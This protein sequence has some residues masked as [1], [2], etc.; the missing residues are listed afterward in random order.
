MSFTTNRWVRDEDFFG[1]QELLS[2]LRK[3]G[4]KAAWVLGNRR[5]G[6][7]S[8][9][10]QIEWLCKK[11]HWPE[12]IGLYW[13]LQG[14]ATTEGLK[15]SFLECLEDAEEVSA[16]LDLDI[17]EME[18]L[19]FNA[20]LGKFR[21]KLKSRKGSRLL[22]LIDECEELVDVA[23]DEP[24][25]LNSFR[26]LTQGDFPLSLILAGSWR[27]MELDESQTRTSPLL[28]DF[29][30]PLLLGPLD[31]PSVSGL[32]LR[33]GCAEEVA[34]SIYDL[35]FGNPHLVQVIGEHYTRIGDMELVLA[36]LKRSHI[37]RSFFQSNFQCLPPDLRPWW[38]AGRASAQLAAMR[39]DDP[40]FAH[41]AQSCL[42]RLGADGALEVSPLLLL[43]ESGTESV[44]VVPAAGNPPAA[45][46]EETALL[47]GE[48]GSRKVALS[49][50]PAAFLLQGD[51][52]ALKA[53][54]NPPTPNLLASLGESR[55]NI[56]AFLDGA[57]PEYCLAR[58]PD[59]QT[60]VYL[61]GLLLYR[62]ALGRAAFQD[63]EDPWQR[64][65]AIACKDVPIDP[66]AAAAAGLNSN[67]AMIIMRCL[68]AEPNHRYRGLDA[69]ARD[70]NA[71]G[72]CAE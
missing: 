7:T 31:W 58:N 64:A 70:L 68:K 59:E 10:R 22:L 24:Q 39:A 43:L 48:L 57:S 2:A 53:A 71:I 32:L 46:D 67:L 3:R 19:S 15:D 12:T 60:A 27:L 34:R 8:L 47:I 18:G 65:D 40:H 1:R 5:V 41:A 61:C 16:E 20:V 63:M 51:A 33:N 45:L 69:L 50:L 6:K 55:E 66:A 49:V 17:D 56:H 21:R 25:V 28:P 37:L 72:G 62:R 26:K 23:R 14:A 29:L 36:E 35:S 11:G 42:V 44:T 4:G 13:D 38:A 9:L 52:N 30:P 54:A